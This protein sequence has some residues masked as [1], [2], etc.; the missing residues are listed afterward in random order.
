MD[1]EGVISYSGSCLKGLKYVLHCTT[2]LGDKRDPGIN[3]CSKAEMRTAPSTA[4]KAKDKALDADTVSGV[5]LLREKR[6]P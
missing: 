4:A 6:A 2:A 1:R 3:R 5:F